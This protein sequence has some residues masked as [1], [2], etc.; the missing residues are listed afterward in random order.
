MFVKTRKNWSKMCK[1]T[2][3]LPEFIITR[4][5]VLNNFY[6]WQSEQIKICYKIK[7]LLVAEVLILQTPTNLCNLN[8]IPCNF[9]PKSHLVRFEFQ[10]PVPV[11]IPEDLVF[12]P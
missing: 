2:S 3:F 8:I 10:I 9:E 6:N 4:K 5:V 11:G 1:I 12:E 7:S